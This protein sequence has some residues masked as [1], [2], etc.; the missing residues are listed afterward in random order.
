M[1]SCEGEDRRMLSSL[2][3]GRSLRP[4]CFSPHQV[5][6][7]VV[8]LAVLYYREKKN[9]GR[10]KIQSFSAL[11]KLERKTCTKRCT[12]DTIIEMDD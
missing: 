5:V 4:T 8:V 6:V 7:P 11:T 10:D 12:D 2:C 3:C 1:R 9:N